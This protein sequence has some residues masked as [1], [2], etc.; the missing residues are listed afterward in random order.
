MGKKKDDEDSVETDDSEE[1]E[2]APEET[3]GVKKSIFQKFFTPGSAST[4]VSSGSDDDRSRDSFSYHSSIS[5][6]SDYTGESSCDSSVLQFDRELRAKHRA[7]CK[8]MTVGS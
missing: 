3:K 2:D 8:N 6:S 4:S 5:G 7:A 1:N